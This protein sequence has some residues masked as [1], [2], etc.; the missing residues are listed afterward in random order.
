M[1]NNPFRSQQPQH[2]YTQQT[3]QQQ[4]QQQSFQGNFYSTPA[5]MQQQQPSFSNQMYQSNPPEQPN[6]QHQQQQETNS[7]MA[8][9]ASQ[10]SSY[11]GAASVS[12]PNSAN[13]SYPLYS[14]PQNPIVSAGTGYLQQQQPQQMPMPYYPQY[15]NTQTFGSDPY[16]IYI[17]PN[18]GGSNVSANNPSMYQSKHAPV[19]ASTLLKG[20]QIRRLACP[21]CQKM[22]EGDDMAINHHVN[23]HYN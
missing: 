19:D 2:Q 20:T 21:V 5:N 6:W 9:V 16:N 23:E 22:L 17:P 7:Y 11:A 4:Q 13:N 1:D 14:Q 3:P 15:G 18:F 10:F 8:P 12:H